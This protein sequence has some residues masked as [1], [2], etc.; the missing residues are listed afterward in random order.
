MLL[1]FSLSVEFVQLL[2]F[3]QG[4]HIDVLA[5]RLFDNLFL[6]PLTLGKLDL[7]LSFL[8]VLQV[9]SWRNKI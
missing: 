7:F 5:Y 8:K 9:V 4:L 3:G 1:L 2:L 6:L